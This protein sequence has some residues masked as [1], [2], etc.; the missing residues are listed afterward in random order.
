MESE[1]LKPQ[2][3]TQNNN[4]EKKKNDSSVEVAGEDLE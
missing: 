2:E 4:I 1:T 3:E